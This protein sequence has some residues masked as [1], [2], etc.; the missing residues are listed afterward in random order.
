MILAQQSFRVLTE[1]LSSRDE[2]IL[3]SFMTT[4]LFDRYSKALSDLASNGCR[5]QLSAE[6]IAAVKIRDIRIVFGSKDDTMIIPEDHFNFN[7]GFVD[8]ILPKKYSGGFLELFTQVQN[9]GAIFTVDAAIEADM[10]YRIT[11]GSG[12]V[13]NTRYSRIH[14]VSF[15]S[16]HMI[17]GPDG[18]YS[19]WDWL[20]DDIDF[21]LDSEQHKLQEDLHDQ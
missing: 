18:K 1:R 8:Y 7:A 3:K 6:N 9:K 16:S 15:T 20:M 2:T 17:P 10:H 14:V 21:L 11:S 12:E 4:R 13:L 19:E 5:L